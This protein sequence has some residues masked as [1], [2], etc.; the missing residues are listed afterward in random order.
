LLAIALVAAAWGCKREERPARLVDPKRLPRHAAC[1]SGC[2]QILLEELRAAVRARP[3]VALFRYRSIG[4]RRKQIDAIRSG[5]WR[6]RKRPF[7]VEPPIDWNAD[8]FDERH[9]RF[10][11]NAMPFIVP[12]LQQHGETGDP[13]LLRFARAVFLDWIDFNLVRNRSNDYRWYDHATGLRAAYLAYII[14]RSLRGDELTAADLRLLLR[15]AREHVYKLSDHDLLATNNHALFQ[16]GGLAGLCKAVPEL[17][18]C[19]EAPRYAA[20]EFERIVGS[21]FTTDAIHAENSPWYQ[22]YALESIE[23]VV[24]TGWLDI[25]PAIKDRLERAWAN[26]PWLLRPDGAYVAI[27]DSLGKPSRT[28]LA[29][30]PARDRATT[31]RAFPVG[32]YGIVRVPSAR[33][34]EFDGYLFLTAAWHGQSAAHKHRDALTFEWFDAGA[35]ILVD[36][37]L[38][39]TNRDERRDYVKSSRA[40]NTITV[41]GQDIDR[42]PPRGAELVATARLGEIHAIA[43]RVTHPEVATRHQRILLYAAGKWLLVHD[44]VTAQAPRAI[45]AW[46]HLAPDAR[47]KRTPGA[48][49]A[50]ELAPLPR[51]FQI[52]DLTGQAEVVVVRGQTEPELQGWVTVANGKLVPGDAIGLSQK[53]RAVRFDT[54]FLLDEAKGQPALVAGA[55]SGSEANLCWRDAGGLH[56][57]RAAIRGKELTLTACTE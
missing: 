12:F 56:G 21:Q 20:R 22:G 45:T 34:A 23:A 50:A 38:Y 3:E 13:A 54:L 6:H 15:A 28:Q 31:H 9:W 7:R 40:H 1:Q 14:D 18:G 8:P 4:S 57:A 37:G 39:S 35:P 11:L 10:Q 47:F 42:G 43:A 26:L 17:D 44:Q 25:T 19:A 48:V 32:G 2:D 51:P 41:D 36:S 27:G 52:L 33:G 24:A 5:G 55:S 53:G 29:R 30:A 46:F 49:G 16:L